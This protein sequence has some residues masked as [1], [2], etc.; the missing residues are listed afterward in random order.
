MS[1]RFGWFSTGRDEAAR[2][3][4][5]GV[6]AKI[7]EDFIP[8]EISFV[9]C[10]RERGEGEQSDLFLDLADK[11]G[12]KVVVFSSS[13]FRP[14]LRLRDL[15]RWREAYHQEV[16]DRIVPY[17]HDLIVL[18]GYMLIVSPQMCRRH[19]MINLH[20]ALPGGPTGAW[21]QVIEELIRRE[22]QVTGVMM[23]LVTE[24]LDRGPVVTYCAFPIQVEDFAS[25][26][27]GTLGRE[28]LFWWIRQEGV[29]REIPLI[30]LTLKALAEGRIRIK[31]GKVMDNRGKEVQ[32]ISLTQEVEEYLRA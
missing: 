16:M 21:Q 19:P 14:D 22:A 15:E 2:G 20:P 3:L 13:R 31:D 28:G 12:L 10:N 27:E 8:G 18:A 17:A 9:F 26:R 5:Q 29:R 25:Q 6:W 23:H 4:L 30:V 11:L 1:F 24:E 7:E 32:G